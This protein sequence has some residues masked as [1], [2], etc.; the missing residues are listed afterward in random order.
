MRPEASNWLDFAREDFQMAALAKDNQLFNQVCFHAQQAV[1]KMLKALIAEQGAQPPRTH[2]TADLL[3]LVSIIDLSGQKT[4]LIRLDRFYIPTR[5]PDALPG[6][7]ADGMPNEQDANEAI[8]TA[9]YLRAD[10]DKLST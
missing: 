1:E 2:K 6:L 8:R 3:P 10:I 5:Y 9:E 7:L 4:A